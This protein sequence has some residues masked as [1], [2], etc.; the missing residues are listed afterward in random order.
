MDAGLL[1]VLGPTM[2]GLA[3]NGAGTWDIAMKVDIG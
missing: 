1:E 2:I 3:R